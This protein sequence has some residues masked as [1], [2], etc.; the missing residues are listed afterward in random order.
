MRKTLTC[1]ASHSRTHNYNY[2]SLFIYKMSRILLVTLLVLLLV[3]VFAEDFTSRIREA[4]SLLRT[5]GP[6]VQVLD[7]FD[8]LILDLQGLS[9]QKT[10]ATALYNR[11]L[12]EMSLNKMSSAIEDLE[13]VFALD[14]DSKPARNTY[15]EIMVK[16]GDFAAVRRVMDK[17]A[18]KE[19]AGQMEMWEKTFDKY[20]GVLEGKLKYDYD[21]CLG[22]VETILRPLTPENIAV[23]ELH[24]ACS[25]KK[26]AQTLGKDR[27]LSEDTLVG[28]IADY[29]ALLKKAP[30][31]D[32]GRYT[33][34]AEY[35]FFTQ[36][37]YQD[38]WNAVKSCLRIDNE[39]KQC[40]SLSKMFA[41]LATILKLL[42]D[43]SI[44][45]G[46]IYHVSDEASDLSDEKYGSFLFDWNQ[47]HTFLNKDPIKAPKRDLKNVPS[48]VKN[49]F[50]YLLWMANAF[51][52]KELGDEKLFQHFKF[53]RDL[54]RLRCEAAL[55]SEKSADCRIY[56]D[57]A[58]EDG[59]PFFPKHA[60][61]IDEELKKKNYAE[62]QKLLT[63]FSKHVGK[64]EAFKKRWNVIEKI[65]Q[66]Q[67][68]QQQARFQQDQQRQQQQW[69]RQQ[70]QQQQQQQMQSDPSKDFYKV[71][72]ILPDADEKTIKKAYRTQTL[73]YHP[74][75]YKGGDLDEKGVEQKMQEINEAYEVLSDKESREAYDRGR[76]G[77]SQGPTRGGN[78]GFNFQGGPN[79]KFDFGN[80]GSSGFNFGNGGFKFSGN[81]FQQGKQQRKKRRA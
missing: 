36:S 8:K 50:D 37:N 1:L 52:D 44:L 76:L 41:R 63:Q 45:D 13:A 58:V 10:L 23:L 39:N 42:E 66:K 4:Q 35:L 24:L 31:K 67:R 46:Y 57:G 15:K 22:A 11:A 53:Y 18:D 26:S 29:S 30:Q 27:A 55:Y 21:E 28:M 12:V 40:G 60:A 32:L 65:Q 5:V 54:T 56:C 17:T 7:E 78:R 47:I 20:K 74:D 51:A 2:Y 59:Q 48:S 69:Y 73:K 19:L 80:F 43:Y 71:L 75:K 49:N 77:H 6:T 61:R 68:Q 34:F 25:K 81:G 70:Q 14:P 16:R 79:I 72:D 62:A 33:E 9:D 38:A 3:S 64:T